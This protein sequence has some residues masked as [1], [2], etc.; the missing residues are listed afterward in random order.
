MTMTDSSP[1]RDAH[2]FLDLRMP[3]ALSTASYASLVTSVTFLASKSARK[4]TAMLA[5]RM[6]DPASLLWLL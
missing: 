3:I 5:T 6:V 2:L 4:W 1:P